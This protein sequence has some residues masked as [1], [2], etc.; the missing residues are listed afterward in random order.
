MFFCSIICYNYINNKGMELGD[1]MQYKIDFDK[2]LYDS[3]NVVAENNENEQIMLIGGSIVNGHIRVDTNSFKWFN[4]EEVLHRDNESIDINEETLVK[5]AT[6]IVKEGY[7]A[8]FMIHSHPCKNAYDDFVYGSLSD[9][10]LKNSKKL[11]LV[12]QIQNVKY[13]D[14][15]ATGK[16]IYFW[17]ID[18][19]NLV[20]IQVPCYVD[21]EL[22]KTK[23]P[24]TLSELFSAISR[25][26]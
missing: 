10:D 8:I 2:K 13:F 24:A 14:G 18:N 25:T 4:D 6:N 20:P 12:C 19:E 16:H 23:V 15:I 21:G 17:S 9:D 22:I 3:I 7:N 1:N 26:K 11:L 5:S